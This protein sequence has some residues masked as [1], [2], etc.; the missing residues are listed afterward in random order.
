MNLMQIYRKD[1]E[2]KSRYSILDLHIHNLDIFVVFVG[3]KIIL[4]L[5]Q[6]EFECDFKKKNIKNI[7]LR[8]AALSC[9]ITYLASRWA[10]GTDP[11]LRGSGP[12]QAAAAASPAPASTAVIHIFISLLQDCRL[13]VV[14]LCTA[15]T[16]SSSTSAPVLLKCHLKLLSLYCPHTPDLRRLELRPEEDPRLCPCVLTKGQVWSGAGA[17]VVCSEV[18][19]QENIC[20]YLPGWW[21]VVS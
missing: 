14:V 17:G 20:F 21:H 19:S 10:A 7:F 9:S 12:T 4:Q 8:A 5:K 13:W 6:N 1:E 15:P 2:I 3:T 18:V 16:C 11:N